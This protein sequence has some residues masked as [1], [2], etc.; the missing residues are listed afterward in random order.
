MI[1]LSCGQDGDRKCF[2]HFLSNCNNAYINET[3]EVT[4]V[5]TVIEHVVICIILIH[6][7]L[8][9]YL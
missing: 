6:K 7:I 4:T 8:S 1:C 2:G 3:T 5:F 9:N